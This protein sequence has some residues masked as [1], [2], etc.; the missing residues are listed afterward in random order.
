MPRPAPRSGP[1][2]T[3]RTIA[4][5]GSGGFTLLEMVIVLVLLGILLA[6]S[7]PSLTTGLV[8]SGE[9]LQKV[10]DTARR[11]A[12][13]RAEWL[14]LEVASDGRWVLMASDRGASERVGYGRIDPFQASARLRVRLSPLGACWVE[15]V[16]GS[17]VASAFDPVR[18]R[19]GSA[20]RP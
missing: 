5:P 20:P 7:V 4:R 18:C 19:L 16:P 14:S 6:L 10:L 8:G 3:T 15:G 12:L 1:P 9:P 13:R 17:G 2:A 11:A